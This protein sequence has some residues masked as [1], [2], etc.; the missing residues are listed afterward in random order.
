MLLHKPILAASSYLSVFMLNRAKQGSSPLL[1]SH[2]DLCLRICHTISKAD[3]VTF[4]VLSSSFHLDPIL[5]YLTASDGNFAAILRLVRV[6]LLY[7]R[8]Y[9]I[10]VWK[11]LNCGLNNLS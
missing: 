2:S 5:T 6:F 3:V 10:A 9:Y 11:T 7:Y 8:I 4:V 1:Y